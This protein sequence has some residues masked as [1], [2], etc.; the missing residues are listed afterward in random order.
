MILLDPQRWVGKEFPLFSRF[1][2]PTGFEALR[3]G[4]WSVLLVQSGCPTCAKKMAELE[5]EKPE[6]V[7]IVVISSSAGRIASPSLPVFW[8]DKQNA[9][10]AVTPCMIELSDGICVN[11]AAYVH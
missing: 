8:L 7:A 5:K 6:N 10:S 2:E 4:T 9:W 1:A 3:Q 11:V